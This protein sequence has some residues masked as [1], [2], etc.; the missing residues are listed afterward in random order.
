MQTQAD[1]I[2]SIPVSKSP[3]IPAIEHNGDKTPKC[4]NDT[5]ATTGMYYS[6]MLSA[7]EMRLTQ[8]LSASELKN[9]TIRIIHVMLEKSANDT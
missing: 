2:H 6:V 9:T 3:H 4:Y 5:E 1:V 7:K 8:D